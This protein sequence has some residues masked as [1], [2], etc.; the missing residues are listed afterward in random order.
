MQ[1]QMRTYS[2]PGE[3]PMDFSLYN[4]VTYEQG[5]EENYY[6]TGSIKALQGKYKGRTK[7]NSYKWGTVT[8]GDQ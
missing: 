4:K 1:T 3:M 6:K 8:G 2:L 5:Q 7:P